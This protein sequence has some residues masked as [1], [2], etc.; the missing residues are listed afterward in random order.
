[1]IHLGAPF[2]VSIEGVARVAR[3]VVHIRAILPAIVS[4]AT[5]VNETYVDACACFTVGIHRVSGI[6]SACIKAWACKDAVVLASSV[7]GV[8]GVYEC[9]GFAV[10][11][12]IVS[13]ITSTG[14]SHSA[15]CRTDLLTSTITER[16]V[17]CA[18]IEILADAVA[19]ITGA[20]NRATPR[21]RA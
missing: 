10:G 6:A 12:K 13:E 4:A 15:S 19:C 5:I 11:I 20:F 17:R 7:V 18:R 3:A 14:S 1:M 9:A 16:A 2:S 8:T 21:V